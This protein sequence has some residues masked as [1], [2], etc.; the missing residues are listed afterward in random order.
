MSTRRLLAPAM[1]IA[2]AANAALAAGPVHV[3]TDEDGQTVYS[4][5]A[6]EDNR[7]TR[8]VAPPPPPAETPETARARL[9]AQL[10][11][12]EDN[13]EDEEL[14][15]QETQQAQAEAAQASER[16]ATARRNLELLNGRPRQLYQTPDGKVMRLSEEER[17]RR[18]DE[19]E[20]II[21]QDCK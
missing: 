17:Q 4:Q 14:A 6:P 8:Q 5:F 20:K 16:C 13:R 9:N 18:R 2:L 1:L 21:A 15:R 7:K 10:Q 11:Q 19:M 12:F 3:W